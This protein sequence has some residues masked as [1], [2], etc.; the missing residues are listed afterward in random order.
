MASLVA[1]GSAM[2]GGQENAAGQ[3][4]TLM[5]HRCTLQCMSRS[6]CRIEPSSNRR[7]MWAA[8]DMLLP[9]IVMLLSTIFM[10]LPALNILLQA[11]VM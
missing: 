6:A 11:T 4:G 9:T 2:K 3:K 7:V 10:L 8:I 1:I 5:L